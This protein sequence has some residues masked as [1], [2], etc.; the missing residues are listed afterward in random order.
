MDVADVHHELDVGVGI[1]RSD[2]LRRGREQC[3]AV[4]PVSV[5]RERRLRLRETRDGERLQ[6]RRRTCERIPV[7]NGDAEGDAAG[8]GTGERR[9]LHR[10]AAERARAR[11]PLIRQRRRGGVRVVGRGTERDR[12]PDDGGRRVCGD[13]V[14]DRAEV[15]LAARENRAGVRHGSAREC[16]EH[17]GLGRRRDV[18]R[19]RSGARG[20]SVGRRRVDRDHVRGAHGNVREVD[21][22]RVRRI[23]EE[24]A[25]LMVGVG[26]RHREARD[27]HD[28]TVGRHSHLRGTRRQYDDAGVRALAPV[29]STAG[30][31]SQPPS[32]DAPPTTRP[33]NTN[34]RR[35]FISSPLVGA[36]TWSESRFDVTHVSETIPTR[37]RLDDAESSP[38]AT[39][40]RRVSAHGDPSTPYVERVVD[41]ASPRHAHLAP[42]PAVRLRGGEEL[43]EGGMHGVGEI[44]RR[45]A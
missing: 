37:P 26:P 7:G 40:D 14:E 4:R 17:V 35:R 34:D 25:A 43:F 18:E 22:L 3:R 6:S 33:A 2:Q 5:E 1:D 8:R 20:L 42:S 24:R 44:P 13:L 39:R 11:H 36:G 28:G 19:L 12:A 10:R 38:M 41:L 21:G 27:A 30:E 45:R 32:D 15:R 29:R 31:S 23:R 9:G 16:D